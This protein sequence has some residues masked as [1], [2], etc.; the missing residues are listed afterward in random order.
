[1]LIDV[2]K[3]KSTLVYTVRLCKVNT[4]MLAVTFIC[5]KVGRHLRW[6]PCQLKTAKF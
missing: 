2:G 4:F 1:M 5:Y 3:H 6:L